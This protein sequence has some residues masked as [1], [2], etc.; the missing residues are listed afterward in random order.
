MTIVVLFVNTKVLTVA[1]PADPFSAPWAGTTE[2]QVPM[3]MVGFLCL[4]IL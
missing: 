4:S 3:S 2:V 1:K